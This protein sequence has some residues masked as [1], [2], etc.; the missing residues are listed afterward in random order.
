[1]FFKEFENFNAVSSQKDFMIIPSD[2]FKFTAIEVNK[3]T[4]LGTTRPCVEIY[5]GA[6]FNN[7]FTEFDD[8]TIF[9]N[10]SRLTD[11]FLNYLKGYC[12]ERLKQEYS[13]YLNNHDEYE[14]WVE[15]LEKTKVEIQERSEN[16]S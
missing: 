3:P 4:G 10:L 15:S 11:S 2:Q 7:Y 12:E 14:F 6:G 5:I 13:D 1:M 16:K 9:P 8:E